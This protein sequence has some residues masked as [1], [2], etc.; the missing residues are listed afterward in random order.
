M[1]LGWLI[2][3]T[4]IKTND[5]MPE[6][7]PTTSYTLKVLLGIKYCTASNKTP[8]RTIPT[9][10]NQNL[11]FSNAKKAKAV[12]TKYPKTCRKNPDWVRDIFDKKD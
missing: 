9:K 2:K 12:K 6:Q 8:T 1:V 5:R 11:F 7:F 10:Y 4:Q 3:S